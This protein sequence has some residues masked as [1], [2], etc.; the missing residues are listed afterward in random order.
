MVKFHNRLSFRISIYLALV[1]IPLLYL[2]SWRIVTAESAAAEDQ[3]IQKGRT[4][5]LAGAQAYATVLEFGVAAKEIRLEDLLDPTYEEIK[6]TVPVETRRYHTKY[7]VYTDTHGIQEIQDSFL[8]DPDFIYA[9]GIDH[10]GYVPTPHARYDHEPTGNFVVDRKQS[11]KKQKYEGAVHLA[12]AGFLGNPNNRTLVQEYDR[13][14]G[15]KA[16]D[17]AAPIMVRGRHFGAFRVGVRFDRIAEYRTAS[18]TQ[19][20][21]WFGALLAA[22]LVLIFGT[23]TFSVQPLNKLSAAAYSMSVGDDL[24]KEIISLSADDRDY[25]EIGVMAASLERL[26]RGVKLLMERDSSASLRDQKEGG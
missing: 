15:G 2:T 26:R 18:I 9:S 3:M 6:Y 13:D 1:T 24:Y 23:V 20:G 4:A 5:A 7:D 21:G 10:L 22:V 11:R 16:W 12:A 8:S 19:I 25:N 17:I 14:T